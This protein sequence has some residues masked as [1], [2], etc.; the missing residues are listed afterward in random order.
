MIPA[1]SV[2][3]ICT[4]SKALTPSRNRYLAAVPDE[5]QNRAAR[6]ASR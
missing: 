4:S 2:V 6:A 5:A 1:A 3:R